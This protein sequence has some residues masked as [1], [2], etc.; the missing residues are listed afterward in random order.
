MINEPRPM[1]DVLRAHRLAC[2]VGAA[3][4][5]QCARLLPELYHGK[6][7][8]RLLL[9]YAERADYY[10]MALASVEA[11]IAALPRHDIYP[12]QAQANLRALVAGRDAGQ[13]TAREFRERRAYIMRHRI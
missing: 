6:E 12:A 13:V 4:A 3:A 10:R 2:L 5:E 11:Q 7:L 8:A 1:L 9:A